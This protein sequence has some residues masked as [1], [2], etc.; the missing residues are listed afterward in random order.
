M[1]LTC[2]N[3]PVI[4]DRSSGVGRWKD[5]RKHQEATIAIARARCSEFEADPSFQLS[6][7]VPTLT[8]CENRVKRENWKQVV[9]KRHGGSWVSHIPCPKMKQ[10]RDKGVPSS[11]HHW[12]A[13]SSL[14]DDCQTMHPPP[15]VEQVWHEMSWQKQKPWRL[16]TEAEYLYKEKTNSEKRHHQVEVLHLFRCFTHTCSEQSL[17]ILMRNASYVQKHSNYN[18]QEWVGKWT[19][20]R[21]KKV[22]SS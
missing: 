1:H 2:K 11:Y 21:I 4:P 9:W 10:V 3:T 17:R 6:Q 14:V 13:V 5:P 8:N 22:P 12:K 15:A 20:E 18:W 16:Q 7:L 19:R